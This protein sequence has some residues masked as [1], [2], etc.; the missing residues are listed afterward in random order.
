MIIDCF[1]GSQNLCSLDGG[2]FFID[3]GFLMLSIFPVAIV[4]VLW[5]VFVT[6]R[7]IPRG[8]VLSLGINET[9]AT[10]T[11]LYGRKI[12]WRSLFVHA[13]YG[14]LTFKLGLVAFDAHHYFQELLSGVRLFVE[15]GGCGC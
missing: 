4:F 9:S 13:L 12:P 7:V 6:N 10:V 8:N 15:L 14:A 11:E 2:V 5:R 3:V 1:G